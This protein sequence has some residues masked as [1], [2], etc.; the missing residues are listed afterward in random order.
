MISKK[1]LVLVLILAFLSF[2][3][4]I[5]AVSNNKFGIHITHSEDLTEAANLVNSN[6]GN[7]G[8]VTVVIQDND[9]SQ[10]KWQHFFDLAREKHLIPLVRLATRPEGEL[11][12]KPSLDSLPSWADFLDSLN[13][14]IKNRYV[15]IYNEPNHTKEW[16]GEVNP[17]EYAKILDK[18]ITVLKQKNSDFLVLNAGFDQAA[19]NSSTTMDEA[20]FLR[21]VN[22]E[23]PGI[24]TRLDGWVSHAYPNHGFIGKPWETG[25]ASVKGYEWELEL[26]KNL[27]VDKNLSVFITETGWPYKNEKIKNEKFYK[28]EVTAEF[29]KQAFENVWLPDKKVTAVTPFILNYPFPPFNNFSW[30]NEEGNPCPQFETIK[31]LSKTKGEPVQEEK[32]EVVDFPVP[33]FLPANFLFKGRITL[34]N[35]GQSIWGEKPFRIESSH[36]ETKLSPLVLPTG[37]L[38]KPG[39]K[40]TFDYVFETSSGGGVVKISWQ[41]LPEKETKVFEAWRLTNEKGSPF[42]RLFQNILKFWYNLFW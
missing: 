21:E 20:R 42:N 39:E 18:A 9:R 30:L 28:K 5:F 22:F 6:G 10:D 25:R 19:P 15:V 13:W 38:V 11:W 8:Y 29:I 32:Y 23:S 33:P 35:N 24:F 36:P 1:F 40:W 2:V 41:G 34:K 17:K 16:G 12:Q 27:G 26:L 7:W 3:S 14:P 4:P 31:G 37:T